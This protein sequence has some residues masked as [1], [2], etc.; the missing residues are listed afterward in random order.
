M[1]EYEY[2]CYIILWGKKEGNKWMNMN[3]VYTFYLHK[4]LVNY[5][6][7]PTFFQSSSEFYIENTISAWCLYKLYN[8][9]YKLIYKLI[10][11]LLTINNI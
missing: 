1:N 7:I 5:W 11:K 4:F 8:K 6:L 10:Y 9:L 3:I 2:V